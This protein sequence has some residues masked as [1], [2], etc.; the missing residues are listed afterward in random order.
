MKSIVVSFF[1]IMGIWVLLSFSGCCSDNTPDTNVVVPPSHAVPDTSDY[2]FVVTGDN[3]VD[4]GEIVGDTTTNTYQL[5]RMFMEVSEMKPLP[6]MLIFNGDLVFGHTNDTGKLGNELRIWIGLFNKSPLA[7]SGVKLIAFTG[8]H[9]VGPNGDANGGDEKEFVSIMGKYIN[10]N[11]GPKPGTADSLQTDQSQLTYSFN[12][13][14]DHYVICNTDAAGRES[15]MPYHWLQQDLKQARV[16]GARHIFVFGHKPAWCNYPASDFGLDVNPADRDSAWAIM[17]R[18]NAEVYFCSHQHYW[19][20]IKHD[21]GKTWEIIGGNA[22]ADGSYYKAWKNPY[23]GY[24]VVRV[25]S[26]VDITSMGR[27]VDW[28]KYTAK[29]DSATRVRAKFTIGY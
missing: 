26:K 1:T 29:S 10:G 21:A 24:T 7:K 2:T 8:N 27:Y 23:F 25:Y 14:S 22:G 19:D 18:Y 12:L 17:E 20:S 16:G 5:N 11:N 28:K 4:Q 15:R 9:E 13:G 6:K 3:R